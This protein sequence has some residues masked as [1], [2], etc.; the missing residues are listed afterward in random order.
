M[1]LKSIYYIYSNQVIIKAIRAMFQLSECNKNVIS[2]KIS[3]YI[4]IYIY[5][6]FNKFTNSTWLSPKVTKCGDCG[7]VC[8]QW[9][10]FRRALF[11]FKY[12]SSLPMKKFYLL[13]ENV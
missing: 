11:I 2:L 6:N 3:L 10:R 13:I 8:D 4:Y 9:A 12:L 5:I 1:G 7:L